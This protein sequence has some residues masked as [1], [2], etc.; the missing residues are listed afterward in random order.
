MPDRRYEQWLCA[1]ETEWPVQV[2]Y[3][4]LVEVPQSNIRATLT[5]PSRNSSR[6]GKKVDHPSTLEKILHIPTPPARKTKTYTKEARVLT[7]EDCMMEIK[8]KE[9]KRLQKV[10]ERLERAEKRK[11]KAEERLQQQEKKHRRRK[12]MEQQREQKQK[13][14]RRRKKNLRRSGHRRSK[15]VIK[16]LHP[17]SSLHQQA[18]SVR[19]RSAATKVHIRGYSA[20]SAM[21]GTTASV[22]VSATLNP[23]ACVLFVQH[24]SNDQSYI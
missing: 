18:L 6:C 2:E 16:M 23:R 4:V 20:A 24:A 7:S 21:G 3:P 10:A 5:M 19:G 11:K 14:D 1:Q 22:Q 17:Q 8:E 9:L 13:K 12:E 15:E